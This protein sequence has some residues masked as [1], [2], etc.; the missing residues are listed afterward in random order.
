MS[1]RLLGGAGGVT[2]CDLSG[3][4]VLTAAVRKTV[5]PPPPTGPAGVWFRADVAI[6][7]LAVSFGGGSG[8]GRLPAQGV[9]FPF[10][11]S[12]CPFLCPAP[13]EVRDS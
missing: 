3:G 4:P 8:A 2:N 7:A 6:V 13:T 10:S 11:V 5:G 12:H 9:T 1:A